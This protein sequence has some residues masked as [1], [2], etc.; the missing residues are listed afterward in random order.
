MFFFFSPDPVPRKTVTFNPGL[1]AKL[2]ARISCLR[3]CDSS[4]QNTFGRLLWNT[5]MIT[6]NVTLRSTKEGKTKTEQNFSAGLALICVLEPGLWSYSFLPLFSSPSPPCPT[7]YLNSPFPPSSHPIPSY[8]SSFI[9]PFFYFTKTRPY[10][11]FPTHTSIQPAAMHSTTTHPSTH[12]FS[13]S[14]Y[15]HIFATNSNHPYAHP[16]VHP[17]NI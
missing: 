15:P 9:K 2:Q 5:V 12:L 6:R 11:L 16:S 10:N 3:T 13:L 8:S 14:F 17:F 1:K 7:H 4:S